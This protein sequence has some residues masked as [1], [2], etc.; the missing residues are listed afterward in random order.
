[1]RKKGNTYFVSTVSIENT[2]NTANN[3]NSILIF[4]TLPMDCSLLVKPTPHIDLENTRDED[5]DETS[6]KCYVDYFE[7]NLTDLSNISYYNN[8]DED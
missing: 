2:V 4:L 8:I 1:M 5:V 7:C 6:R 3:K